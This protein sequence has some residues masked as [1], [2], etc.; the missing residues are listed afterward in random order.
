MKMLGIS[1]AAGSE[2]TLHA[3]ANTL[4]VVAK[5]N[6]KVASIPLKKMT[7]AE[8]KQA[9]FCVHLGGSGDKVDIIDA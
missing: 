1:F 2:V 8:W 4:E 7:E 5:G 9:A 6:T 3:K